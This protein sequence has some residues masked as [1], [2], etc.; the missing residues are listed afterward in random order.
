M[1]FYGPFPPSDSNIAEVES[2]AESIRAFPRCSNVAYC[3]GKEKDYESGFHYYGARY[4]WSELLTGW[5]S[6]DPMADKYPGISPYA[7]CEDNPVKLIDP[8]GK[9]DTDF[10]DQNG[11]R[12]R[13]IDD[14]SDAQFVLRN[15][16]W[17]P[18]NNQMVDKNGNQVKPGNAFFEFVG[19]DANN[20]NVKSVIDFSQE[21]CKNTYTNDDKT[22]CNFAAGFIIKSFLSACENKGFT[23][24]GNMSFF[25][26]ENGQ[27]KGASA[28]YAN[29]QPNALYGDAIRLSSEIDDNHAYLA[30]GCFN[31]HIV[32]FLTNGENH[33]IMNIGGSKGN[34]TQNGAWLNNPQYTRGSNTIYYTIGAFRWF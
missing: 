13:H 33:T 5:L 23:I 34:S 26:D 21:F 10:K 2:N 1:L 9:E 16:C 12:I 15:A 27:T 24:D 8:D 18:Q 14:G 22:Y 31:G 32:T 7:Y 11:T 28:I 4:Y 29:I 19:G 30:L 3:N 6:V 17:D 25:F 20:I